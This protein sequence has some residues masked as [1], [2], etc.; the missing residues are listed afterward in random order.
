VILHGEAGQGCTP[1]WES[2]ALLSCGGS[3]EQFLLSCSGDRQENNKRAPPMG[4]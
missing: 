4:F 3:R 1:T 2:L